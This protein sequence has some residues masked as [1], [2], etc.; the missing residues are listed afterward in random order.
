MFVNETHGITLN[1]KNLPMQMDKRIFGDTYNCIGFTSIPIWSAMF[2]IAIIAI[3]T[4]WSILMIMI[5]VS[6]IDSMIQRCIII[7]ELDLVI[8][9]NKGTVITLLGKRLEQKDEHEIHKIKRPKERM[10]MDEKLLKVLEKFV[11]KF[12]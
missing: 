10:E 9:S 7:R 11:C 6:W 8:K 3:I 2:V 1:L 5:F 12:D 4:L